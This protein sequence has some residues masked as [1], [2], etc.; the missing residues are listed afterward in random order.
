MVLFPQLHS[1]T[2]D[3]GTTMSDDAIYQKL[4][5]HLD[6]Q[7]V[8]FPSTRGGSEIRILMHVFSPDEA[9]VALTMSHRYES[10]DTIY[11]RMKTGS[12]SL[13]D[14]ESRLESALI[15]GGIL[16]RDRKSVV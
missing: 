2:H 12:I 8:G 13:K 3:R 16:S 14:V 10:A 5:K 9:A 4:R 15:K 11:R 6:K 7:P 1:L